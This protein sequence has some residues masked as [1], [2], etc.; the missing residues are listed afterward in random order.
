MDT[1]GEKQYTI[2]KF[3]T[4]VPPFSDRENAGSHSWSLHPEGQQGRQPTGNIWVL[5]NS[6]S[7]MIII[8][9]FFYLHNTINSKQQGAKQ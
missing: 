1:T 9:F 8:V 2:G 6:L 7:W 4:G 3:T 5:L